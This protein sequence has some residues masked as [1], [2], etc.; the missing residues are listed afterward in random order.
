MSTPKQPS[1]LTDPTLLLDP[2]PK[3]WANQRS[4]SP[5]GADNTYVDVSE[6]PKPDQD[7]FAIAGEHARGGLGRIL[8]ANDRRLDRAIAIKELLEVDRNVEARFIREALITAR[9]Q[10]PAIVPI[11]DVGRWPNGKPFYAM[12]LVSGRSLG[13]LTRGSRTLDER[14]ALIPNVIAVADAIAY[15]HEQRV[16]HRDLKPSNVM[17]GQFGETMV[18]DWGLATDL[19]QSQLPGAATSS[20]YQVAASELT[21]AGAV[22]GTPE[23][24]PLEQAQG[25]PVDERA[26]VYSLGAILYYVLA[27]APPYSGESSAEV[28]KKVANS[29]PLPLVDRQPGVPE[30]LATIVRK[31]MARDPADRYATAK[32]LAE[33]LK[34]FQ[35]GQ[36]VSA[37]QY[38]RAVLIHR[39][40]RRHRTP[41]TVSAFFMAVL[42]ALALWSFRRILHEK[43]VAEARRN[44]LILAQARVSTLQDPTA[45]LAWLKTYP[46]EGGHWEAAREIALSANAEGAAKHVLR[47]P[48]GAVSNDVAFSRDGAWIVSGGRDG[49]LRFWDQRT[50]KVLKTE[51]HG[52][53]LFTLAWSQ[54]GKLLAS[55]DREGKIQILDVNTWKT[56]V[57]LGHGSSVWALAFLPDGNT[58]ASASW[59]RTVRLWNLPSGQSQV[60]PHQAKVEKLTV[61]PDGNL[62]ATVDVD[63]TPRLWDP[64]GREIAFFNEH[65]RVESLAFSP[66]NRSLVSGNEDGTVQLWTIHGGKD[67]VLG[68]HEGQVNKVRFSP[69]GRIVASAGIDQTVRLWDVA[70]GPAKVLRGFSDSVAYIGFSPV[71]GILAASTRDGPIKL[72]EADS[73]ESRTLKGHEGGIKGFAFSSDGKLLASAGTE[74][75]VRIWAVELERGRQ[76]RGHD[77]VVYHLEFSADDRRLAS[78]SNDGT[79]RIW[80]VATTETLAVLKQK[81]PIYQ[82]VFSPDQNFI[83]AAGFSETITLWN[84]G[85]NEIQTLIGHTGAVRAVAFAPDG[86]ALAS[87]SEDQTVRYWDL[88]KR[89]YR[90]I[91]RGTGASGSPMFSSDGE[92]LVWCSG[93]EVALWTKRT[94]ET[95][96]IVHH[97]AP[98]NRVAFSPDMKLIVSAGTDRTVRLWDRSSG[99]ERVLRGHSAPVRTIAFSPDGKLL[100]S[101]AEDNTIRLWDVSNGTSRILNGHE[102]MVR[103]LRF[104]PDGKTIVS[105]SWDKTVRLWDVSTGSSR[106][107]H[108]HASNVYAVAISKNGRH[109]ASA[110]KDHTVW[111]GS[112][113]TS[114]AP[115]TPHQFRAWLDSLT[116][117]VIGPQN[118]PL[119]R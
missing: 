67:R 89:D 4:S 86:S 6:W 34:R 31:A 3:E 7:R 16:I 106:A 118:R 43:N 107:L 112:L 10:H 62:L 48:P 75:T 103:S 32:E 93:A 29:L 96:I 40:L 65:K 85:T 79:V 22:L 111:L 42:I 2:R 61:S 68:R 66:D 9:L 71:Q 41:V 23:Y 18:I 115:S 30:D 38:S 44:E 95:R 27:G 76:L 74:N 108:K 84:S 60:L 17:I 24:M 21:A 12:K 119:T 77:N 49:T 26:D 5:E 45:A 117:A 82:V 100:A 1:K 19:E 97:E 116:T 88:R 36:L 98:V 92:Y 102:A 54:N 11:Y 104:S 109:V 99:K 53:E 80:D 78:A 91:H 15:A 57:L 114:S 46:D 39:W 81:E 113:E 110:S 51:Q 56:R 73:G 64:A 35:T 101:G 33:D 37:R 63:R 83:A 8:R 20:P 69:D 47:G 94:D 90:I 105:G 52:G 50:G 14:L 28:I 70:G 55:G 25:K 13:D 59:D 72:W 58:L 87:G